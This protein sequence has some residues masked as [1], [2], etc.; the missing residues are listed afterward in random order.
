MDED[1]PELLE[2]SLPSVSFLSNVEEKKRVP[3]TILTGFLGS[4]KTTLLQ[5]ILQEQHG[6]KIAVLM[7]EFGESNRLK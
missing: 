5:Y 4:G 7:N 3:I 1:I 2:A 6:I